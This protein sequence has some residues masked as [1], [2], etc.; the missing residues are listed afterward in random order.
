[1]K[2]QY[3]TFFFKQLL[4]KNVERKIETNHK[5]KKDRQTNEHTLKN[6]NQ[7]HKQRKKESKKINSDR[8]IKV[9]I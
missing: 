9:T 3:A 6:R 8:R 5:L 4:S 2:K 1:M 7:N